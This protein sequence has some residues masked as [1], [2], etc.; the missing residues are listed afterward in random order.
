MRLLAF[1][2]RSLRILKNIDLAQEV[3]ARLKIHMM[4]DEQQIE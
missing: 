4:Q 2:L 1:I 3:A